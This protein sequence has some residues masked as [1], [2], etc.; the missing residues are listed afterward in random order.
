MDKLNKYLINNPDISIEDLAL[1]ALDVINLSPYC[2]IIK[3]EKNN[4]E[5]ISREFIKVTQKLEKQQKDNTDYLV[6]KI[7]ERLDIPL[8]KNFQSIRDCIMK[9]AANASEKENKDKYT[10]SIKGKIGEVTL[11]QLLISNMPTAEIINT[12][13]LGKCGDIVV[14]QEGVPDILIDTKE[15]TTNVT[16]GEIDKFI[17]D[18]EINNCSGILMSQKSGI[19]GKEHQKFE[20]H[21]KNIAVYLHN[22]NYNFSTISPS[23]QIIKDISTILKSTKITNNTC[24]TIEKYELQKIYEE[25]LEI[26]NSK[27]EL[28]DY[29]ITMSKTIT[30]SIKSMKNKSLETLIKKKLSI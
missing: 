11:E 29:V 8:S 20:I 4:E 2:T 17:R 1:F 15:W 16:K 6:L 26:E 21:G 22:V 24:I 25:Y 3:E 18:M 9:N 27:K 12:A 14:K 19:C 13:K 10:S 30:K 5:Y 28:L 23:I 7:C